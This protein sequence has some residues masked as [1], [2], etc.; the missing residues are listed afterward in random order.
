MVKD[1][2]IAGEFRKILKEDLAKRG[3]VDKNGNIYLKGVKDKVKIAKIKNGRSDHQIK[4]LLEKGKL[5]DHILHN[6]LSKKH[7]GNIKAKEILLLCSVGRLVKNRKPYSFNVLLSGD[8]SIGKDHL[9]K[10]VLKLIPKYNKDTNEGVWERWTRISGKVLNYL[11]DIDKEE[12]FTYDGKILYLPEITNEALNNEVMLEFTGGDEADEISQVAISKRRTAGAD[13]PTI[14][15]KPE[16]FCSSAKVIPI[17]EIIDRYN[18]IVPEFDE[19][20]AEGVFK[21]EE[22]PFDL[23]VVEYVGSLKQREI[24]IPIRLRNK[25]IKIFPKDKPSYN[26][27]FNRLLD[28]IR[29]Y[30]H[31]H[32]QTISTIEDYNRAK[33]IFMNALASAGKVSLREPDKDIVAVLKKTEEGLTVPEIWGEIEKGEKYNRKTIYNHIEKLE[34]A[35]IIKGQQER[36]LGGYFV[37]KYKL[38]EEYLTN[39]PISLP[40]LE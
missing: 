20:Q 4:I 13:T 35:E 36:I 37:T 6:E 31:F 10:A 8:P 21:F 40:N 7:H 38:T 30:T 39:K 2:K 25:I 28:F 29:A 18:I 3:E 5:W 23:A 33:D 27:L 26:R 1:K 15:G 16:V 14:R 11:H 22:D 19:K 24:E 32:G 17:R 34:K 9:V 12:N